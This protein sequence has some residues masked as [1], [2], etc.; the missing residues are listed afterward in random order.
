MGPHLTAFILQNCD[1]DIF[2]LFKFPKP[3]RRASDTRSSSDRSGG[4]FL[5][6]GNPLELPEDDTWLWAG[7]DFDMF[8]A[9]L[10]YETIAGDG[11]GG[12][13]VY[14]FTSPDED[15][16]GV[17]QESKRLDD[18]AQTIISTVKVSDLAEE[19][20]ENALNTLRYLFSPAQA[21]QSLMLYFDTWHR[22]CRIIHRPSFSTQSTSDE[23][24]I[25]MIMLG[26]MYNP[27][28]E[29]R[30]R[31]AGVID[32]VDE[33]ICHQLTQSLD[34]LLE[35][36]TEAN[37]M[38]ALGADIHRFHLLQASFLVVVTQYWTG[39]IESKRKAA[40]AHF[41]VVTK[42]SHK[43]DLTESESTTAM[44]ILILE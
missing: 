24:L 23:L 9:F 1:E 36:I 15:P 25:S 33:Y 18:L 40:T 4:V 17:L 44:L 20:V 41:D 28:E 30:E 10:S 7:Q 3:V 37:N 35:T 16:F 38:S 8:N 26:A 19:H 39:S 42:V 11:I 22:N 6:N 14:D 21:I 27:R 2:S 5:E 31:A 43:Q 32:I 13:A 29:E 12:D 34:D